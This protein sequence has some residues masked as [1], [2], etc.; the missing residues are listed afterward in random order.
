MNA[1]HNQPHVYPMQRLLN[2]KAIQS[3]IY[4]TIQSLKEAFSLHQQ[5]C[6]F[7]S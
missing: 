1:L 2:A 4:G 7:P 6:E 3:F 5:P